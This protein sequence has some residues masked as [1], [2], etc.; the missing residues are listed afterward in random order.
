MPFI[1]VY[2]NEH[3]LHLKHKVESEGGNEAENIQPCTEALS[4]FSPFTFLI[5]SQWYFALC[6]DFIAWVLTFLDKI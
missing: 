6:N 4:L 1:S 3:T 5:I 2:L